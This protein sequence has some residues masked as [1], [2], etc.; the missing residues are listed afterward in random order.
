MMR[1]QFDIW[2]EE[3]LIALG[4]IVIEAF[5]ELRDTLCG[6]VEPA[7]VKRKR[8][9]ALLSSHEDEIL[10][11]ANAAVNQHPISSDELVD[12]IRLL[13]RLSDK[14]IK[15]QDLKDWLHEQSADSNY[16]R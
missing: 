10:E 6:K 5:C 7:T 12:G 3:K 11:A 1:D 13:G 15:P 9:P 4:S 14:G 2:V 8:K 16:R